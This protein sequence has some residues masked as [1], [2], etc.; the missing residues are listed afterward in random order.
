MISPGRLRRP[1]DVFAGSR[2]LHGHLV[3]RPQGLVHR[4]L[5]DERVGPGGEAPQVVI[6]T[7]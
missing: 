4:E 2:R 3:G 7:R 5:A 1:N 6:R